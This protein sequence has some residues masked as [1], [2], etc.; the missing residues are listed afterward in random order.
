M[1][2]IY[3]VR[4]NFGGRSVHRGKQK[5]TTKRLVMQGPFLRD[6]VSLSG[7]NGDLV[8]R[9]SMKLW[10]KEDGHVMCGIELQKQ[11][12]IE[13]VVDCL[14]NAFEDKITDMVTLEILMSMHTKLLPPTIAPGLKFAGSRKGL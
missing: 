7:P 3:L 8:P 6:L 4:R 9:Q 10:L 2:P 5:S 11:W 14:R 12:T 13:Q 1:P